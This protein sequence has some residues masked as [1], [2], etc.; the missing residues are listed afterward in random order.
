M[1]TRLSPEEVK[2]VAALARLG[3]T[4]EEVSRMQD[5]LSTILDHIAVIDRLDTATIPPTAHVGVLSNVTRPDISTASLN[6]EA[7]LTNAPRQVDGFFAV[8]SILATSDD[9]ADV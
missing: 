8:K 4:N 6:R 2:Y 7:I 9:G 3:L 1:S 5:Q